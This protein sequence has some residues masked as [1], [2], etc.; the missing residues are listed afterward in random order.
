MAPYSDPNMTIH[1]AN[2]MTIHAANHGTP[3]VPP[4][5]GGGNPYYAVRRFDGVQGYAQFPESLQT[6][7]VAP[8]HQQPLPAQAPDQTLLGRPPRAAGGVLESLQRSTGAQGEF[9]SVGTPARWFAGCESLCDGEQHVC[10]GEHLHDVHLASSRL[11]ARG[12]NRAASAVGESGYGHPGNHGGH[13]GNHRRGHGGVPSNYQHGNVYTPGEVAMVPQAGQAPPPMRRKRQ[14]SV[15]D[16]VGQS[17]KLADE[18]DDPAFHPGGPPQAGTGHLMHD[19]QDPSPM[20]QQSILG[21]NDLVCTL[22]AT[23]ALHSCS[24]ATRQQC[25]ACMSAVRK[26]AP[27]HHKIMHGTKCIAQCRNRSA[28]WTS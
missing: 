1:A 25:H 24:F 20:Q 16:Y 26:F 15:E 21:P 18:W 9:R 14:Q 5:R 22:I 8:Q 7:F 2:N 28:T 10:F 13:P 12:G 4:P 19:M 3:Y 6:T 11:R 27:Q 23:V 17:S